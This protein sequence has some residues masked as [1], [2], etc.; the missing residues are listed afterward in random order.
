MCLEILFTTQIEHNLEQKQKAGSNSKNSLCLLIVAQ[1]K[2]IMQERKEQTHIKNS[3]QRPLT[4]LAEI[5]K[6]VKVV[7]RSYSEGTK[8]GEPASRAKGELQDS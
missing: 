1:P 7:I 3:R 4:A 6:G 5:P 8:Y 2:R